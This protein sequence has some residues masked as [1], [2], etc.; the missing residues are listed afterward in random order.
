MAFPLL[1]S[2]TPE[3]HALIQSDIIADDRCLTDDHAAAVVDKKSFSDRRSGM[4]LDPGLSRRPLGDPSRQK[5]LLI[6][7]QLIRQP[8]AE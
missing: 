2:R 4:D 1:L 8:L 3:G 5:I 7:V 6:Q